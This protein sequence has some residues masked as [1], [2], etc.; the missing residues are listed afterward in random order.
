ML[1]LQ[2]SIGAVN[3]LRDA[4]LDRG[5]K[6]GKPIPRGVISPSAA[7]AVAG[8]G[9]I[10]GLVLSAPSGPAAVALAAIGVGLGYA[11]DLW[12]S[13]TVVSWLPLALALPL[14]PVYAWFGAVGRVPADLLILV[15]VAVLA[16]AGLALGNGLADLDRDSAAG[17]RTAAG[18]LGR[19]WAWRLQAAAFGSVVLAGLALAPRV[20]GPRGAEVLAW[21]VG[22][23]GG[24]VLVLM[25][26][27]MTGSGGP[28]RARF[29]ERGWELE[30]VGTALLGLAWVWGIAT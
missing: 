17:I 27:A 11:Y 26:V 19:A 9:L 16:G 28:A 5:R 23:K 22:L 2:V 29:R 6:P 25:G 14:L 18:A 13:R 20:E 30:A 8:L 7:R 21:L 12:L 15:P 1:A 4:E 3:D 24:A 10:V